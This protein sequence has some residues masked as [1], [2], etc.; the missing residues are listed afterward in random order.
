VTSFEALGP[1]K[2][3]LSSGKVGHTGTLDKFAEGLLVVL[4]GRAL[5]LTPCILHADKRYEARVLFGR[6]TDTLDPEG[7]VIAGAPLPSRA[8]VEAAL[9]AFLGKTLQRPPAYSALHIGGKRASALARSGAA[10]EMTPREITI[11]DI[12]LVEWTPPEA[13]LAV[14]CAAGVYIRALARDIACAAGSRAH[15]SALRRTQVG[16]FSLSG[17]VSPASADEIRGALRPL[18]RGFFAAWGIA[19][20][21]AGETQ[22]A[23]LLQGKPL[24]AL[25]PDEGALP[26]GGGAADGAEQAA[27]FCGGRFSALLVRD[28]ARRWK[29]GFVCPE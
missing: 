24:A 12:Q 3:A 14:H 26:D 5:K 17:A 10:P 22:R 1:V 23:A 7:R 25:F 8:A 13:V 18:D 21:E 6:E 20:I 27:V 29:Y 19:V 28:A 15:L 9:A 16:P 2:K 4:C 11:Y